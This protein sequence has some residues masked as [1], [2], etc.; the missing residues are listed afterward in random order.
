MGGSEG[1]RKNVE[2]LDE[3]VTL[4]NSI[5]FLVGHLHPHLLHFQVSVSHPTKDASGFPLQLEAVVLQ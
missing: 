4:F 2:W 3:C 5:N 1:V